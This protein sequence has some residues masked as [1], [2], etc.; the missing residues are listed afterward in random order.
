M[1]EGEEA[2]SFMMGMSSRL[3]SR[4]TYLTGAQQEQVESV[5]SLVFKVVLVKTCRVVVS[6]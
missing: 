5:V 4:L 3:W 6:T 1:V 2:L